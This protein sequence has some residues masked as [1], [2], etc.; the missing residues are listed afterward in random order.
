MIIPK[1]F[2]TQE[3]DLENVQIVIMLSDGSERVEICKGF[4]LKENCLIFLNEEGTHYVP[5][6]SI[7]LFYFEAAVS[8]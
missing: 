4:R 1:E 3:F 5:L 7:F 2:N 6:T 8:K